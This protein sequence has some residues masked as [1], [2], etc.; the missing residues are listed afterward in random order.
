[1]ATGKFLHFDHVMTQ[2]EDGAIDLVMTAM[3]GI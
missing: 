3:C 1:M 2:S